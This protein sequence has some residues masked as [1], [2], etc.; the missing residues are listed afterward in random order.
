MIIGN[1]DYGR[2]GQDIPDVHPAHADAEWARAYATQSL[3]VREGNIIFLKDATGAQ[4]IRVFGSDRD[5]R[6]QLFDWVKTGTRVF[7]YYAGHG[8]PA[9]MH[10]SHDYGLGAVD[11]RAAVRL[12]ETWTTQRTF[13][14][15]ASAS[16]TV[17]QPQAI[18]GGADELVQTVTV[19]E[20]LDIDHVEPR[21][22]PRSSQATRRIFQPP[23]AAAIG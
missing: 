10:V 1:G 2:Q 4:I 20:G 17:S 15:E 19:A 16:Y 3:G 6:G 13:T 12:A 21:R 7:V 18:P 5:H 22:H 9:G 23:S 14:N 11:A 8:A